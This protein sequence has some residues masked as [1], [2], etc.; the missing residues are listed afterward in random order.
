[1]KK[2]SAAFLSAISLVALATGC[3][4]TE[5]LEEGPALQTGAITFGT[6]NVAKA[7][8]AHV[9]GTVT[10]MNFDE[11]YVYGA[12][13]IPTTT[14]LVNVFSG[15]KVFCTLD[16]T[17]GNTGAT[18]TYTD[19]GLRYWVPGANYS[20]YGF[21][22]GNGADLDANGRPENAE[23]QDGILTL[24]GYQCTD[25]HQHDL[26]F[27]SAENESRGKIGDQSMTPETA[28]SV[29][30][31]FK[32]ILTRLKFSFLCETPGNG[33]EIIIKN[34][35]I[36]G[37]Y[38]KAN[39]T[40]NGTWGAHSE[41]AVRVN[42]AFEDGQEGNVP[43]DVDGATP[44]A[45]NPIFVIPNKYEKPAED[46]TKQKVSLVFDMQVRYNGKNVLGRTVEATWTPDWAQGQ[47]LNN[48]VKINFKD[49]AG[50]QPITF[51]ASIAPASGPSTDDGWTEG[52]GGL[53][54]MV[55]TPMATVND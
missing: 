21:S 13:Q 31:Q 24:S 23:F 38:T 19:G 7:S 50:L 16:A 54:T 29:N 44:L 49:A 37:M 43:E 32:H 25:A 20:F 35:Y 11:F 12:Y 55:F 42:L 8:R 5:I 48:V 22:C 9:T 15:V 41:D 34:A 18:W 2:F 36:N 14:E 40:S 30:M 51:T 6:T 33:Y 39:F 47:S 52:T 3:S 53:G 28:T 17:K 10:N 27:A 26:I 46:G 1:M 45:C 4:S